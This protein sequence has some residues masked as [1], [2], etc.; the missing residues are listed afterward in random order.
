MAWSLKLITF[1]VPK[2]EEFAGA[3]WLLHDTAPAI[4]LQNVTITAAYVLLLAV[5]AA[6][7]IH[8]RTF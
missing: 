3:S 8:S 2:L 7:R 4:T 5:I 6:E 1:L